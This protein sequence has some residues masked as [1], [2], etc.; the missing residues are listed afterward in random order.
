MIVVAAVVYQFIM[1]RNSEKEP[2]IAPISPQEQII[3]EPVQPQSETSTKP[4]SL[5]SPAP[6]E[7]KSP[8][9]QIPAR[10]KHVL[11]IA[12][13]DTVWI[14]VVMD[15]I[16][17][18]EALMKQ[19]DNVT[20]DANET[21]SVVVGNAGGVTM[22]FDGRELPV[23]KKGEVLRITL[24]EQKTAGS[25]SE[26]RLDPLK[27]IQKLPAVLDQDVP[28]KAPVDNTPPPSSEKRAGTSQP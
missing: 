18:R 16:T 27:S 1:S 25:Q 7:V 24:P 26:S 20:Y 8:E 21:V 13:N 6:G 10:K 28:N 17:K 23:G 9:N 3:K 19:G 14:K 4:E 12:A 5:K 2:Y 15:G 11:E 22:K